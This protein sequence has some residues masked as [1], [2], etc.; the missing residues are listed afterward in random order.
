MNHP[1][2]S[3]SS[4]SS[5]YYHFDFQNPIPNPQ[6]DNFPFASA[7][8]DP[9]IY[10]SHDYSNDYNPNHPHLN[11]TLHDH[12]HD[13][14]SIPYWY[15]HQNQNQSE[16]RFD[17]YGRP[18]TS[19]VTA[20]AAGGGNYH[21]LL[22]NDDFD[23]P[24]VYAYR[25]SN[26][27]GKDHSPVLQFDDYGRPIAYG[28][29]NNGNQQRASVDGHAPSKAVSKVD[30]DVKNGVQKFRVVILSEGGGSQGDMD[31]LCQVCFISIPIPIKILMVTCG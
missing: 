22:K 28:T 31:V 17:D 19:S 30:E 2:S 3:S 10:Y 11:G 15:H 9:S 16:I 1:Q 23:Q 24:G 18:I 6:F 5:S 29:E 8:P 7:P 21:Q 13:P 20:A 14:N 12:H 26:N 27:F 4:S 25:G